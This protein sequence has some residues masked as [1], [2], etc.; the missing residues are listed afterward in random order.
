MIVMKF[1]GSSLESGEAIFRVTQ[2][3]KSELARNPVVV[4]SAMG[5][6]TNRLLDLATEAERGHS[7]FAWQ[8]LKELQEY[9][10]EEASK[11]VS[12]AALDSLGDSLHRQFT[13][14]CRLIFEASDEGRELTPAL[15]DEIASLGERVSSEIVAAAMQAAGIDSFH[16]DSRKVI[17]TDDNH[18]HATPRYWETYAKLRRVIPVLAADRT[19]VMGG[20]IAATAAGATTTLG[21]GGS[22]LSASIV[23]AGISAEEVQIWT[24]VDGVLS[25][26]PKVLRGPY[27][28]KCLSYD[29]ATAMARAGAKVLHPDTVAP[30]VRQRIPIVVRNS[31][32][33]ECE[34]TRIASGAVPCS[35]PVKSIA[36]KPDLTILE[37]RRTAGASDLLET[38][39][40]LCSR[41]GVAPE[42]I[43]QSG[44]AVYL[45]VKSCERYDRL[46]M[47]LEHCVEA[48]VRTERALIALVG[49]AFPQAAR[50]IAVLKNPDAFA[51]YDE[52][53][54]L[55]LTIVV[56]QGDLS[57]SV[58]LLHR[59]F[60]K[61][62][63]HRVFA[64]S[65]PE[66]APQPET[67]LPCPSRR[68]KWNRLQPVRLH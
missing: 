39:K 33:P 66:L 29:E 42:M 50:A 14:M 20:F 59:E 53:S 13:Q 67:L 43:A 68:M 30:A 61:E 54:P 10:L 62:V 12:G 22:D 58:E 48:R 7:Y 18:T 47:D 15:K 25:C 45:A 35:N 28:L 27:R 24:D 4:V 36:C 1:G 26:D 3:V 64:K 32:R 6:T 11:V 23:G 2:I 19:V 49:G 44:D 41:H 16:L 46:R 55:T 34:G 38:L 63:D 8:S 37:L 52:A 40:Q 21:R 60:F 57:K 5:K 65:T 51:I 31:R 56:A 17:L 9:H